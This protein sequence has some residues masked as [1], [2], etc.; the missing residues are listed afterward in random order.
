MFS[1]RKEVLN[2]ID[3]IKKI[4]PDVIIATTSPIACL[5]L[6]KDIAK[7]LNKPWIA[8]FRDAC[9]LFNP[10]SFPLVRLLDERIDRYVVK[11]ASL[12]TSYGYHIADEMRN[13][14]KKETHIIFNGFKQSKM[15]NLNYKKTPFK[16]KTIYYAGRFHSH[17]VPAVKMLIDWMSQTNKD[18]CLK[19]RSLGPAKAN[20]E[21]LE[22][23]KEKNLESK[24]EL[25]SPASEEKISEEEKQADFLAIFGDL[26]T[27][28]EIFKGSMPGKLFEYLPYKG[29]ILAVVRPDSDIQS[30][31]KEANRGELVCS[32]KELDSFFSK[33]R[34]D[35]NIEKLK[36][37]TREFQTEKLCRL[38]NRVI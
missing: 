9:S 13:F 28:K 19:I 38:F 16:R 35:P 23:V 36:T 18:L 25:L 24:V 29:T 26:E 6:A 22:K 17:R 14:Y 10:S 21:I 27:K 3:V 37:Y 7:K 31:L 15:E 2:N 4:N 34:P 30:V 8:D 32:F 1:W 11:T 33:E 12:I 5:W 20:K